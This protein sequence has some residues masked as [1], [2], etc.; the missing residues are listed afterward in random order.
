MSDRAPQPGPP[1]LRGRSSLGAALLVLAAAVPHVAS[2]QLAD[3]FDVQMFRPTAAP[4]DLVVVQQSRPLGHFSATGSMTV[5]FAVDPLVLVPIGG[6]TKS[7]SVVLNRLQLDAAASVGLF[8][9]VELGVTAPV[10]LFQASDNLEAIGTEGHL[11]S[12]AFGD[13]RFSAKVAVPYLRRASDET[14]FGAALTFSMSAPT[15]AQDAFASEGETTTSPGLVLDYRFK[16]G[17]LLSMNLGAW[18]RPEREFSGAL[19]GDM[20]GGSLGI[21]VPIIRRWGVTAVAMGYG[22]LSLARSDET[23]RQAPAEI[24]GGLRWYSPMG[25]TL[26]SG[27]GGGCG[28]GLGAPS[29]R[30]FFSAVWIPGRTKEYEEIERFKQ[31][32]PDPDKDGVIDERDRCPDKPGPVENNGCPDEDGDGVLGSADACPKQSGTME[33]RGCPERDSDGD[34]TPDRYDGCPNDPIQVRGRDG[35]PLARIDGR[36]IQIL[37]Q[38]HFATD[39]D[40]ILPESFSTLEEVTRILKDHPQILHVLV[41]GHTDIRAS[42]AYNLDLSRRRAGSVMRFLVEH[43]ID[44]ARLHYEG[45]GRGRPLAPNDSEAGMALNRRVEFTIQQVQGEPPP[46]L[47]AQPAPPAPNKSKR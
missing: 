47:P 20:L 38:V 40:V 44:P 3:R 11:R 6:Q 24:L 12:F 7:V 17:T 42:E 23:G 21:E 18:L 29:F 45:F 34:G 32:S 46:K 16:S 4:T 14:G 10:I 31:P 39:Q 33:N 19:L 15:G 28:C 9:W 8:D 1:G 37:D 13:V 2:A 26:T 22:A 41:E 30:L 43:G 27:G 35:C 5:N 36:K 25:V